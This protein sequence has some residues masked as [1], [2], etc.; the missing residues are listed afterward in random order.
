M[1]DPRDKQVYKTIGIKGQMWI[2]ENIRYN[3]DG[4]YCYNDSTKYCDI[5]G[6]FYN[7]ESISDVCPNGWHVP[8]VIEY[9]YLNQNTTYPFYSKR[10]TKADN[11]VFYYYGISIASTTYS[12]YINQGFHEWS[13]DFLIDGT[14]D[15][16][17]WIIDSNK[18]YGANKSGSIEYRE[19]FFSESWGYT[20]L[21]YYNVR[22]VK[23]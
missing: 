10:E 23:D 16:K 8:S 4:S 12:L 22:C 6:R 3:K 19:S 18:S 7:W 5:Y 1:L 17:F 9:D 2:N 14:Q 15:A 20:T 11:N 13:K 21:N